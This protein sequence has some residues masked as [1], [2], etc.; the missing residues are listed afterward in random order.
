M[1]VTSFCVWESSSL[2]SCAGYVYRSSGWSSTPAT[3]SDECACP[4]SPVGQLTLD[5]GFG[6]SGAVVFEVIQDGGI[7]RETQQHLGTDEVAVTYALTRTNG[8]WRWPW[9]ASPWRILEPSCTYWSNGT[10]SGCLCQMTGQAEVLSITVKDQLYFPPATSDKL[11]SI[12]GDNRKKTANE[13]YSMCL[14]SLGYDL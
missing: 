3:S 5:V 13:D 10:S 1:S 12:V 7:P 2:Q 11:L 14:D 4:P 8:G 6:R 9:A